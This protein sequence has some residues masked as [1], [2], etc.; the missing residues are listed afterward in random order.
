[1]RSLR[2]QE[3]GPENWRAAFEE[4]LGAAEK[5]LLRI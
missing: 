5:R 3:Y 1:L 4:P 2:Y